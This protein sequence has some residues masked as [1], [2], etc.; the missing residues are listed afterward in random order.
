[1]ATAGFVEPEV[2]AV[3]FTMHYDGRRRLVGRADADVHRARPTPTSG[4]TSP[5]AA[6]SWP[7]S[8]RPPSR[9]TQPDDSLIIP[10]RTWVA[11]ATA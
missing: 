5:P 10:A 8:K 11:S 7:N 3:D 9:F 1:M 2:E 4:W 6:T